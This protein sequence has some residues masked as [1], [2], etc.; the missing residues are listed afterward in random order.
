MSFIRI[1][2]QEQ[3][4][5][6]NKVE[7]VTP[8]DLKVSYQSSP[9]KVYDFSTTLSEEQLTTL[10]SAESV[11]KQFIAWQRE[12]AIT[13]AQAWVWQFRKWHPRG[14]SPPSGCIVN[15]YRTPLTML[16]DHFLTEAQIEELDTYGKIDLDD[17]T[18]DA[19]FD[20]LRQSEEIDQSAS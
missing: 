12:G 3:S 16:R 5:M 19:L 17:A 6:L 18:M 2:D 15:G 20:W 9:E 7:M 13:E 4:S 8:G 1:F 10:D 14:D 11:G